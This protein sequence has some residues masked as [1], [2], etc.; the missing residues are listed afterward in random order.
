MLSLMSKITVWLF[1]MMAAITCSAQ[2]GKQNVAPAQLQKVLDL[3]LTQAVQRRILY[4]EPLKLVYSRQMALAGKDCQAE[5]AAGQQPYNICIGAAAEEADKD[6]VTFY[7]NL[8]M[9]CHDQKELSALQSSETSWA[10]Y[11]ESAL[12]AADVCWPE[13]TG[14][15]GF[16]GQVYLSLLRDRMRELDEIFQLRITQ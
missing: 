10:A 12:K 11:R 6:Y 2:E 16:R 15:P 8:Q 1:L 9:L 13:G 14:A 7:N 4:K 5:A 3:P